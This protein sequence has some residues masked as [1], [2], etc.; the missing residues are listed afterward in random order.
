LAAAARAAQAHH[1]LATV[2]IVPTEANPGLGYIEPGEALGDEVWRVARFLE[3]PDRPRAEQLVAAGCLWNSGIFA[4]RAADFLAELRA[5][6][7]ELAAAL[8]QSATAA[9]FFAAVQ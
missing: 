9:D 6:T 7:P 5:L 3:K 8:N 1:G 4:W 2:G